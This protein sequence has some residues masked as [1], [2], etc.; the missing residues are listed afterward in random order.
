MLHYKG[1]QRIKNLR[2][3]LLLDIFQIKINL[4]KYA[5]YFLLELKIIVAR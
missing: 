1:L 3:I 5:N 4:R 2:N